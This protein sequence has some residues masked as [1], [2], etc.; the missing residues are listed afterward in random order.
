MIN[1]LYVE[2]WRITLEYKPSVLRGIHKVFPFAFEPKF[3]WKDDRNSPEAIQTLFQAWEAWSNA[4][5]LK[6]D[7]DPE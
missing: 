7:A 2:N 4:R 5:V 3:D 6:P 1:S